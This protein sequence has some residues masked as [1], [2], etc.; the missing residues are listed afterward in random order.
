MDVNSTIFPNRQS[1]DAVTPVVQPTGLVSVFTAKHWISRLRGKQQSTSAL[2]EKLERL[3]ASLAELTRR[4]EPD[5]VLLGRHLMNLHACAA[6][7][8]AGIDERVTCVRDFLQSSGL[9][10][11]NGLTDRSLQALQAGLNEAGIK[12]AA[13]AEIASDL[14]KLRKYA[15][16]IGRVARL[17]NV[18]GSG[19]AVEG[20]RTATCQRAFGTFIEDFRQLPERIQALVSAVHDQAQSTQ[21]EL[22]RLHASMVSSLAKLRHITGDCEAVVRETSSRMQS[23]I[24]SSWTALDEA[25]EQTRQITSHAE[26]ATY[27]LQFGD[28]VRQKLEHVVRS[29]ERAAVPLD[30]PSGST[31]VILAIQTSQLQTVCMEIS[32]ARARI[33]AAFDGLAAGTTRVVESI[34]RVSRTSDGSGSDVFEDLS[35]SLL[36][37]KEVQS[38]GQVLVRQSLD[39]ATRAAEATSSMS[40]HL[41]TMEEINHQM[42]LQSLN[43]IIKTEWLGSEGQTLGVLSQHVHAVFQESS[44]LV[45]QTVNIL[46]GVTDRGLLREA[47]SGDDLINLRSELDTG[48]H[49]IAGITEQ[50]RETSTSADTLAAQQ[51]RAVSEAHEALKFLVLLDTSLRTAV[52]QI[53]EIRSTLEVRKADD[54]D[55]NEME[56]L[57]TGYTMESER[58]IHRRLAGVSASTSDDAPAQGSETG[59][60]DDNVELF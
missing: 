51:V 17:L 36:R 31:D 55:L 16:Q 54:A 14:G 46:R 34:G 32:D 26:A 22:A 58:E 37:L 12:L 42:R 19:L 24:D 23:L 30:S 33:A 38:E 60:L 11:S 57:S 9:H 27:Y 52:Q 48:L 50:F 39:A 44:E 43:A 29:L 15:Q 18:S 6:R 35:S 4:T 56:A 21:T 59:D 20:A 10:G 49:C 1:A 41:E 5:F 45:Q 40:Q 2:K 47:D 53:E 25:A 8:A 7:T 13:L 28:I 3:A